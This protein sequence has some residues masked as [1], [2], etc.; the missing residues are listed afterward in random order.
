MLSAVLHGTVDFSTTI[1]LPLH[2]LLILLADAS[3]YFKSAARPAPTPL[4]FVGV[5]T[6]TK[7]ISAA[8]KTASISVEKNKFF[9]LA[10]NTISSRPG[11]YIG[12]LSEF[13]W[14]IF[15]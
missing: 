7:M 1:L 5:L 6:L 2:A 15:S 4:V 14:S 10:A 13:H 12:I 11:S 3:M 8:S 9:P